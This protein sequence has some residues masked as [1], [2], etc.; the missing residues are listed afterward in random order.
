MECNINN[1]KLTELILM[2]KRELDDVFILNIN[3]N[4]YIQ[5]I[6]LDLDFSI[7]IR[8]FNESNSIHQYRIGKN[9]SINT[10][11]YIN[12]NYGYIAVKRSEL[13]NIIEVEDVLFILKNKMQLTKQYYKRNITKEISL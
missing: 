2:I 13:L 5:I 1:V 3:Q 4:E 9:P 8:E 7:E 6:K 12:S 10:W 11:V